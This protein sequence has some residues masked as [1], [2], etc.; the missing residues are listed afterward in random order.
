MTNDVL[1]AIGNERKIEYDGVEVKIIHIEGLI[2]DSQF[3]INEIRRILL[4]NPFDTTGSM[5]SIR[6][7]HDTAPYGRSEDNYKDVVRFYD[8]QKYDFV[9]IA[10][11]IEDG[12]GFEMI[13]SRLQRFDESKESM[14]SGRINKEQFQQD[15]TTL[16][17][18][19]KLIK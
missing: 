13:P 15:V 1:M 6:F 4:S 3:K 17:K 14:D 7:M 12:R 19:C 2:V 16:L 10:L 5:M 9:R 8:E 18:E 11:A